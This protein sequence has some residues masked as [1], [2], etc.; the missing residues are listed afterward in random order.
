MADLTVVVKQPIVLTEVERAALHHLMLDCMGGLGEDDDK[1]WRKFLTKLFRADQGEMFDLSLKFARDPVKHC[2]FF[3]LMR[4]G[5]EHWEAK[6]VHKTYQGIPVVKNFET[7]RKEVIKAAG[8]Y[9]QHWNLDG[10]MQVVAKSIAFDRMEDDEFDAL[11]DAAAQVL[12][13][14]VLDNYAGRAELDAVVEKFMKFTVY[15]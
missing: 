11:Y 14:R 1:R 2:K 13:E 12:L 15:Q 9:E 8:Y 10:S 4:L 6:R 3:A 7:F 5:F